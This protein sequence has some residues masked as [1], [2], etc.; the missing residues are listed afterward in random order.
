MEGQLILTVLDA[1]KNVEIHNEAEI[2]NIQN[3]E[4]SGEDSIA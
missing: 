3:V 2:R 1:D 4:K